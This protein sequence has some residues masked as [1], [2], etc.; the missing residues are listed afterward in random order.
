MY[1]SRVVSFGHY[2][3]QNRITNADLE[4][5][6]DTSDA[7]IVERTGIKERRTFTEKTDTVSLMGYRA[8]L[9]ALERAKMQGDEIDAIIFATLS[10]DYFFPGSGVLV[11]RLLKIKPLPCLDVRA[12]CSGFIYALSIADQY[13]RTGMYKNILIIGAEIQTNAIEFSDRG[14]NMSVIFGDG[15]GAAIVTRSSNPNQIVY[16]T[17]IYADGNFAEE[18]FCRH[19]GS[20]QKARL[21]NEMIDNGDLLPYM[22]GNL[23]FKHAVVRMPESVHE[24]LQ[25]AGFTTKDID[26]LVPHQA[27][28][29]ISQMV[30]KTLELNDHQVFNNIEKYGNTTAATIPLALSEAWEQGKIKEGMLICITAFGSGFTWGSALFRW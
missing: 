28:I 20:N 15:A 7:W 21:T 29:R 5:M 14:R 26:L 18:L 25:K 9:M 17:N 12:Q 22:N 24:A 23:V 10:P 2:T 13:I 27:N 6:M 3:P 30:Q 16:N 8:A 1:N 11:Q 4:K 19:P